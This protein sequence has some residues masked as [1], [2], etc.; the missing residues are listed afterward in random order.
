[1]LATCKS[2]C[3]AIEKQNLEIV[4]RTN[5]FENRNRSWNC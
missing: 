3:A 4:C 5:M 2:L 1:M